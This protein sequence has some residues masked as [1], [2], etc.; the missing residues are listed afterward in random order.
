MKTSTITATLLGLIA[1][2]ASAAF[3]LVDNFE[4]TSGDGANLDGQN[5]W[6]AGNSFDSV[7]LSGNKV[8]R[9]SIRSGGS[10]DVA[11]R[12]F[13]NTIGNSGSTS[14]G[15]LFLRARFDSAA[16][17]PTDTIFALVNEAA[18][19]AST[20]DYET[21]GIIKDSNDAN[22]NGVINI[23][24]G[25]GSISPSSMDVLTISPNTWYSIW[26]VADNATN[27]VDVYAK[28]DDGTGF[29]G[30]PLASGLAFRDTDPAALA[31]FV[32]RNNPANNLKASYFDDIYI[33]NDG[34]NLSYAVPEPSTALLGVLG[35]LALLR[36]RRA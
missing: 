19:G 11:F 27:T 10:E 1:L 6:T 28:A 29:T 17:T 26:L 16:S 2:P 35:T 33:D 3:V 7:T 14:T 4:S 34:L 20:S 23:R 25:D 18:P 8:V 13:A 21:Y 36:R 32:L 9:S 24:N 22:V 30:S 5:N 31:T 12:S 15:T